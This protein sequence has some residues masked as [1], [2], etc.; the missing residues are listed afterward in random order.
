M[1]HTELCEKRK[2]IGDKLRKIRISQLLSQSRCAEASGL[3]RKTI[4]KIEN[5]GN[6]ELDCVLL[7]ANFI[8]FVIDFKKKLIIYYKIVFAFCLSIT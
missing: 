1:N 2:E 6:V 3:T 7:Y 4:C 5:G 8:G